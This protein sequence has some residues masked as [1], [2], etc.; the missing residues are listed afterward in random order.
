MW[1]PNH[2]R[3]LKNWRKDVVIQLYLQSG[4]SYYYVTVYNW[5]TIPHIIVGSILSVSIF[6]TG[7]VYPWT[8]VTGLLAILQTFM[9]GLIRH[10]GASEKAYQYQLSAREYQTLLRSIDMTL[11]MTATMR[12]SVDKFIESI[13]RELNRIATKQTDPVLFVI[14]RFNKRIKKLDDMLIKELET[15]SHES[16]RQPAATF[17]T[18]NPFDT[19]EG[20]FTVDVD[21]PRMT[22]LDLVLEHSPCASKRLSSEYIRRII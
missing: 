7:N 4:S 3:I 10:I 13:N 9:S 17:P 15:A 20:S 14:H 22:S 19:P 2:E 12:P 5:I 18:N 1:T 16:Q 11:S 8:I 6:I 21:H